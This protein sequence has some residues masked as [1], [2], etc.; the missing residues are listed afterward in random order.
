MSDS[1]EGLSS[2]VKRGGAPPV[3]YLVLANPKT[4]NALLASEV[5]DTG[6]ITIKTV[7]RI[8]LEWFV[9]SPETW[10]SQIEAA[11]TVP[12]RMPKEKLGETCETRRIRALGRPAIGLEA[13]TPVMA[14]TPSRS[15]KRVEVT[16][17]EAAAHGRWHPQSSLEKLEFIAAPA[18]VGQEVWSADG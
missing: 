2:A 11:T 5:A 7:I 3:G 13:A 6:C 16:G 18:W 12:K 9:T 14:S 10:P 17:F 1:I 15:G 4:R 8:Q